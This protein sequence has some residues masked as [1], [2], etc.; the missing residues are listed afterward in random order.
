M[1]NKKLTRAIVDEKLRVINTGKI[2]TVEEV[3]YS[4]EDGL[5]IYDGNRWY[6]HFEVEHV[7]ET[8][9]TKPTNPKDRLAT[10]RLDLTLF[11]DT[12]IAY[13]ALGMTE[14]DLKYGGY[15][16]RVKGASVSVYIAALGRHAAKYYGG[17]WCDKKTG[18]PHLAS[19]QACTA[20][21]IDAHE[22]G[23]LVDDRPP[24][25]DMD[26]IFDEFENKIKHLQDIFTN[27]VG[28]YTETDKH[29]T[30]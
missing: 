27:P 2:I 29:E 4:S 24:T 23:V 5:P 15:N 26:S 12:A 9:E 13:G 1:S 10:T 14:G 7:P 3:D 18:V 16:Y 21:I 30:E 6:A 22:K 11:P 28:R 8:S 20:I 17:E 19:M 25:V